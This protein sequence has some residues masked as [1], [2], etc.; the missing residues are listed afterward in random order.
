M[1]KFQKVAG[2]KVISCKKPVSEAVENSV[3]PPALSIK[4]LVSFKI[5]KPPC[6]SIICAVILSAVEGPPLLYG[7]PR[8][9]SE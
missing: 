2:R 3:P 9:G 1:G 4:I 5:K 6:G 7:I 8:H